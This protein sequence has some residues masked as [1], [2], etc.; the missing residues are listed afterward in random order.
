MKHLTKLKLAVV[1]QIC[2]AEDKST[3]F[4]IQYM[5]AVC[6]V[7]HDRV[8]DYL[9]L[10]DEEIETLFEEVVAVCKTINEAML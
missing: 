7:N 1:H 4:M 9:S 6:K 5:Q 8:L 3:E 2:D 10:P